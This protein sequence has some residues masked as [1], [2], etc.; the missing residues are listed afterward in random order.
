M[1]RQLMQNNMQSFSIIL[2]YLHRLNYDLVEKLF[3]IIAF[4]LVRLQKNNITFNKT[5]F[6]LSRIDF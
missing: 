6:S 1:P 5:T 3:I 4:I 2:Q